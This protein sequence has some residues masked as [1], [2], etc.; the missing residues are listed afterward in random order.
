MAKKYIVKSC[1]ESIEQLKACKN[2]HHIAIIAGDKVIQK[3]FDIIWAMPFGSVIELLEK[4]MLHTIAIEIIPV[5][6][7][8]KSVKPRKI[9][10]INIERPKFNLKDVF[11]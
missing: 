2:K 9:G 8:V 3:S 11:K 10:E 5:R 1:I 6:N 4:G 7:K